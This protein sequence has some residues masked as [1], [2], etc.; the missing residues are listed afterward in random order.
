MYS[1]LGKR[2]P[3]GNSNNKISYCTL[4][5]ME[6]GC[7]SMLLSQTRFNIPEPKVVIPVKPKPLDIGVVC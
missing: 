3:Y 2:C 7:R 1:T 4:Q 5:E 6:T